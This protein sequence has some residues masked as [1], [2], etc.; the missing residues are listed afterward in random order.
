MLENLDYFYKGDMTG[1]FLCFAADNNETDFRENMLVHNTIAGYLSLSVSN[2][3]ER[4]Y[5][6]NISGKKSL[7]EFFNEK[8]PTAQF[9]SNLLKDFERIFLE[10]KSYML[11]EQSYLLH[12][13]TIY[14]DEEEKV[15][16]CYLPGSHRDVHN[17]LSD[18]FSFILDYVDLSDN[19]SV[20]LLYLAG[21]AAN[22]SNV[23]FGALYNMIDRG[24][25]GDLSEHAGNIPGT[26]ADIQKEKAE[27]INTGGNKPLIDM[28]QDNTGNRDKKGQ[29]NIEGFMEGINRELLWK[30]ALAVTFA[31]VLICFLL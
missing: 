6:Y 21:S 2:E 29:N 30:A 8:K 23:T 31:G 24:L 4:T 26:G 17:Q 22:K 13:D 1:R 15:F 16:L 5:C 27:L 10:G 12:P 19:K 20:Y 25:S 14:M 28:K 9:A 7:R 11:E 18:L 3:Q